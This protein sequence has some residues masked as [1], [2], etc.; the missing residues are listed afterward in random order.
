M[1]SEKAKRLTLFGLT[2][3]IFIEIFL[4]ML[5]G[6]ADTLMLSQYSDKAV[7]AVGVSNQVLSV[8]IVMFGFVAQGAA[9]LI[10]QNL[11]AKN[12]QQAGE[13]SALSISLNLLFSLFLS[14]GLFFGAKTIL[15][16]MDLPQEI[17]GEASS[18][19]QIVGGL[20]FI[21]ALIMTLGAILRSYGYTKDTMNVTIGMNILNVMGNYLVIFGPFGF[22]VL[23]VE[24]VAYST[25]IS[26]FIGVIVLFYLFWKRN[27]DEIKI[28][29]FFRYQKQ[30]VK[31]LLQIG[32]PSAGEQISY[33]ASQMVI[34]YFIAQLG[35]IAITTKVYAQNIMMF[36]F[37]F[38]IAIGQGTQIL[39]GHLVGAGDMEAAYKRVMKSLKIS[40]VVSLSMATIVYFYSKPLLGIFTDDTTILETGAWLLLMTIVL[41]PGRAFNL[42]MISSLRAAGD[43]KFPVYIGVAVMWGI[44][45]TFAWFFAIYLNLGLMGIWISF[46]A[47][48]WLRGLFML[49]R[50]KQRNW[51]SMSFVQPGKKQDSV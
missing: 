5:M 30:Y 20:I 50:W 22:P 28:G 46:I 23:G 8:V 14:V 15:Q 41:E 49:R 12:N 31:R 4:H 45:V 27:S 10:A 29:Y 25:A 36:I 3:P 35:T 19:M 9:I 34:T 6:N 48:E 44:G 7:A 17:M 33:N 24:G 13:I 26:R 16:F 32:I 21:Q 47:D 51:V 40:I 1:S 37:L 11:G 42:I 18:Y 2:W 38:S 39:V 43:V